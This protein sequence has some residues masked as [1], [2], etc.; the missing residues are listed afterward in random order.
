MTRQLLGALALSLGLTLILETGF[1]LLVGKRGRKDLLLVL[2]VNILTNPAVVLLYRLA[3]S[4]TNWSTA[5]IAAPLEIFAAATEG[6]YYKKYGEN[7]RRPYLFSLAANIFSFGAGLL[8]QL[9][10]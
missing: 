2:A 4:Y 10:L 7:F 6:Y 1:F 9:F 5:I 8:I 3:A